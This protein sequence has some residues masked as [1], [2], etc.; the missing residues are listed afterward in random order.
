[1]AGHP[2]ATQRPHIVHICTIWLA[3][4]PRGFHFGYG[5]CRVHPYGQGNQ[6]V[7]YHPTSILDPPVF[8]K[9]YFVEN[10]PMEARICIYVT[11][12]DSVADSLVF[13]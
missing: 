12:C 6:G 7:P 2:P 11:L 3:A 8:L 5:T 1:M 13:F 4:A 9:L 10:V